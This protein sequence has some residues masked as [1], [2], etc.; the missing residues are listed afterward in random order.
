MR[1]INALETEGQKIRYKVVMTLFDFNTDLYN[2][3]KFDD[4]P[5]ELV[6]HLLELVQQEVGYKGFGKGIVKS[7]HKRRGKGNCD[8]TLGR[9]YELVQG[10]TFLPNLFERG[11]LDS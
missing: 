1:N 6:P 3:R 4:V 2:P 11:G 9:V 5:L 10:C 8:P 7:V